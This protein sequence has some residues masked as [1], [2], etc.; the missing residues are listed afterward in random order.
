MNIGKPMRV[1]EV[2]PVSIPAPT[3]PVPQEPA[4]QRVTT[5]VPEKVGV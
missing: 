3:Q 1:Y 5:P 2:K 4:P